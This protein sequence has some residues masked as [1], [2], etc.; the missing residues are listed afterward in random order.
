MSVT[1]NGGTF[2]RYAVSAQDCYADFAVANPTPAQL[3]CLTFSLP[4]T[5]TVPSDDYN[6]NNALVNQMT[7]V[8][9]SPACGGSDLLSRLSTAYGYNASGLLIGGRFNEQA[10]PVDVLYLEG[11]FNVSKPIGTKRREL[12]T[13]CAIQWIPTNRL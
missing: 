6:K 9:T 10:E 13:N 3:R 2:E 5:V 8:D 1:F 12:S 7:F 11:K 4:A